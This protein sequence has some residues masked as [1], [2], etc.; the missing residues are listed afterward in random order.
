M[1]FNTV[2]ETLFELTLRN[3]IIYHFIMAS[4]HRELVNAAYYKVITLIKYT[5][6]DKRYELRKQTILADK[7]LTNDENQK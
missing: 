6:T 1:E 2:I 7:S 5:D 4:I 3:T